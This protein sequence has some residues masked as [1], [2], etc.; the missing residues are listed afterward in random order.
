MTVFTASPRLH[1]GLG[2]H[3]SPSTCV[4]YSTPKRIR[5]EILPSSPLAPKLSDPLDRMRHSPSLIAIPKHPT[6][7][8]IIL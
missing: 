5:S 3:F 8:G 6:L 2:A 7:L 1:Y 4:Q